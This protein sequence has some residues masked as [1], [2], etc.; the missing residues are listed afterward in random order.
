[1]AISGFYKSLSFSIAKPCQGKPLV[2]DDTVYAIGCTSQ[3][4]AELLHTLLTSA[5]AQDFLSSQVFWDAK[6]PITAE[7]LNSI[8]LEQLAEKLGLSAPLAEYRNANP[9]I[10]KGQPSQQTLF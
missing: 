7:I 10:K 4:E 3:A 6:R 2:F 5:E 8:S 1:L 9:W